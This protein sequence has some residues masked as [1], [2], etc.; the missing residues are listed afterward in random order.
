MK[1]SGDRMTTPARESRAIRGPR[2]IGR[3]GDRNLTTETRR[4]GDQSGNGI[5]RSS[6]IPTP[7]ILSGAPRKTLPR[8]SD[9]RGVEGPRECLA[10]RYSTKAFSREFPDAPSV[11]DAS[12]GSFDSPSSRRAGLRLAQNDRRKWSRL[13][14]HVS[15]ALN[16][17]RQI[18]DCLQAAS[19]LLLTTLRE[20]FDENAYE[21]FLRRSQ[22]SRSVESYRAFLL[23][24]EA[25]IARKPRCC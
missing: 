9:W 21:R 6:K 16:V 3:S 20:I 17:F 24:R 4:H 15:R 7:V 2:V 18:L 23:E 5:I 13:H 1:R 11:L 22:I 14:E 12:S 8:A 25:G 19:H 10:S